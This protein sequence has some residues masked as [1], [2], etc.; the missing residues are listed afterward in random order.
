MDFSNSVFAGLILPAVLFAL[1]Y[2]PVLKLSVV[3]VSPYP[4]AN[5]R[6]RMFGAAIDAFVVTTFCCHRRFLDIH[7][8]HA[9][10]T[11]ALGILLSAPIDHSRESGAATFRESVSA[12]I[13]GELWCL[14]A[15]DQSDFHSALV[16]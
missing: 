3:L 2:F 11:L 7:R 1:L 8:S 5:I 16:P 9:A 4:K 13:D 10:L 6:R 14:D 12:V 15:G